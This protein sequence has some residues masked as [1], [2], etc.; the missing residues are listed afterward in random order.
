M[1]KATTRARDL[2]LEARILAQ[3][4]EEVNGVH[5]PRLTH[6][7]SA[8]S[9]GSIST[10]AHTIS[11]LE[12]RKLI[13]K[14]DNIYYLCNSHNLL[15]LPSG[16]S[17]NAEDKATALLILSDLEAADDGLHVTTLMSLLRFPQQGG[18]QRLASAISHLK[19]NKIISSD[20]HT[21]RLGAGRIPQ[22]PFT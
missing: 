13:M 14:C 9:N 5:A 19:A 1:H 10:L 12:N 20:C 21:L 3:I 7:L 15:S 16:P 22:D 17:M 2:L 8:S 18:H 4:M 6:H 11:F